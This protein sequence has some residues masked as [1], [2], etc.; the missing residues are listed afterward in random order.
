[1][2][3]EKHQSVHRGYVMIDECGLP[4]DFGLSVFSQVSTRNI[5]YFW[6]KEKTKKSIL[7]VAPTVSRPRTS[8]WLTKSA[9]LF[10]WSGLVP[11]TEFEAGCQKV[12]AES[13]SG[14]SIGAYAS[15][16]SIPSPLFHLT[17]KNSPTMCRLIFNVRAVVYYTL[18][19]R[20]ALC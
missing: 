6:N 3:E 17:G 15:R 11:G 7:S 5:Y 9:P 18:S 14:L 1:M 8:T 4:G 2:Y 16:I 12:D 19:P 20:R 13:S 10:L